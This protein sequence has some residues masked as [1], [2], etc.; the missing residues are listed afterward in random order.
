MPSALKLYI[1]STS[2]SGWLEQKRIRAHIKEQEEAGTLHKSAPKPKD[3]HTRK[4]PGQM[5]FFEKLQKMAED[6]QKTQA[7]RPTAKKSR[8]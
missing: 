2:L 6:A 7:K 4:R 8:R 3:P 1:M 5:S